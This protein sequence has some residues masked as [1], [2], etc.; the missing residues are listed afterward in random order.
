MASQ[1]PCEPQ[2]ISAEEYRRIF[3]DSDSEAEEVSDLEFS[4]LENSDS[5]SGGEE[6]AESEDDDVV[7]DW[8][9]QLSQVLVEAFD[10]RKTESDRCEQLS[11]SQL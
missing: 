10:S 3:G 8:T 9:Q 6:S 2:V 7:E 1:Y 11:P 4:G 5:E